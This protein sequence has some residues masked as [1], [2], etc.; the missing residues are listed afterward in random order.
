MKTLL[1]NWLRK[2]YLSVTT[3]SQR[4]AAKR[5]LSSLRY[6]I[7]TVLGVQK[8]IRS[9]EEDLQMLRAAHENSKNE[10]LWRERSALVSKRGVQYLRNT[11]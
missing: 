10:R 8:R 4:M 7:L 3:H 11:R 6:A 1:R 5:V 9:L 2:V